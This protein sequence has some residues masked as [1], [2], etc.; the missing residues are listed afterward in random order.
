[1]PPNPFYPPCYQHGG[2]FLS[3]IV[4]DCTN[5]NRNDCERF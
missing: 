3:N 4:K 1:L 5:A 2:F